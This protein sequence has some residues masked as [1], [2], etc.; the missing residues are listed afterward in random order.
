MLNDQNPRAAPGSSSYSM[1]GLIAGGWLCRMCRNIRHQMCSHANRA[2]A[3]PST[4][5][6]NTKGFVQ[7]QVTYIRTNYSGTGR[8]E[9]HTSELQSPMRTS[10]AVFCLKT[11]RP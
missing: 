8:S 1:N 11:N 9:E 4:S 7:V 2:H 10:Y 3:W 5:M 6:R